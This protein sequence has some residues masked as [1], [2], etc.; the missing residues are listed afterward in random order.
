MH[1][2]GYSEEAHPWKAWRCAEA[3]A[4][5]PGERERKAPLETEIVDQLFAL[6][7]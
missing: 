6:K 2:R 7:K 3:G 4:R 5:A 1:H